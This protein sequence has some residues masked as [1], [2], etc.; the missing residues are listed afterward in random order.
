MTKSRP[1]SLFAGL[2][3]ALWPTLAQAGATPRFTRRSADGTRVAVAV[4]RTVSVF[5]SSGTPL[6]S[7]TAESPVTGLDVCANGARLLYQT[8]DGRAWIHPVE[9]GAPVPVFTATDS[10]QSF[11]D[12][13]WSGDCESL[14]YTVIDIRP[15]AG[16]LEANEKAI[17]VYWVKADGTGKKLLVTAAP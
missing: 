17:N 13:S 9:G 11:A 8:L 10:R 5:D 12:P 6:R 2:L 7:F 1:L 15:S 14:V 3:L 4:G 16:F